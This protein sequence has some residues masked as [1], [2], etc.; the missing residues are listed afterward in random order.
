MK[1]V[2]VF[3]A[4]RAEYGLLTCLLRRIDS[5]DDFNLQIIVSGTHLSEQ[6]GYTFKEIDKEFSLRTYLAPISM[7]EKPCPSMAELSSQA[8]LGVSRLLVNLKPD[9]FFV[10]GDR[11]ETFAAAGA[12]HLMLVGDLIDPHQIH[13]VERLQAK[14][15]HQLLF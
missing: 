14:V 2:C 7:D 5:I 9:I 4:T 1:N 13:H 11:Y 15:F 3:T 8:M 12:L 10:L 6:F